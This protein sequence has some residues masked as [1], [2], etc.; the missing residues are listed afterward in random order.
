MKRFKVKYRNVLPV[1]EQ[2]REAFLEDNPSLCVPILGYFAD[3][4]ALEMSTREGRQEEDLSIVD[5]IYLSFNRILTKYG[6][7]TKRHPSRIGNEMLEDFGRSA[8]HAVLRENLNFTRRI[9]KECDF[10]SLEKEYNLSHTL[11]RVLYPPRWY[12]THNL[13]P[14]QCDFLDNE[15]LMYVSKIEELR[16]EKGST[17][18]K[19]IEI[20]KKFM[21]QFRVV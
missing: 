5:K 8:I 17:K 14:A 20:L 16:K 3:E 6:E 11:E 18:K 13:L 10:R 12:S 2:S 9:I 1:L 15:Y 7:L 4:L 21:E 19:D